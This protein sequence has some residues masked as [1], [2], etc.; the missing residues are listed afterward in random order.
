MKIALLNKTCEYHKLCCVEETRALLIYGFD[1]YNIHQSFYVHINFKC[2]EGLKNPNLK[3]D[4]LY[5]HK[6][7]SPAALQAVTSI[8]LTKDCFG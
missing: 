3:A 7:S 2:R 8:L 1:V 4:K 5:F 6:H